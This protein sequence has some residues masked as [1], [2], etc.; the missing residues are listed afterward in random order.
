M[1]SGRDPARRD[2]PTR[3]R[4]F[5]HGQIATTDKIP[6]YVAF[7]ENVPMTGLESSRSNDRARCG[8]G[9]LGLKAAKTALEE[10]G[11]NATVIASE[12]EATIAPHK[13]KEW[14]AYFVVFISFLFFLSQAAPRNGR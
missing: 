8:R 12:A 2:R 7:V 13:G 9:E 10:I 1:D 6:R 5:C 11:R 3:L 14:S 4:S